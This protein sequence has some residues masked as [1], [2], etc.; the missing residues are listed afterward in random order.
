MICTDLNILPAG[1]ETVCILEYTPY[2]LI[3]TDFAD[4]SCYHRLPPRHVPVSGYSE[5]GL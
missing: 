1:V 4:H 5:K 2:P 3:D